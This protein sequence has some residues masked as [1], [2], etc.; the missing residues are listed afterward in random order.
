VAVGV[1]HRGL[2]S[3]VVVGVAGGLRLRVDD[4]G[5]TAGSVVK[6]LRRL[7]GEDIEFETR[8]ATDTG[9]V[10]MDPGQLDQLLMNLTVN[11]RDA[12]PDGG[13]LTISTRRLALTGPQDSPSPELRPGAYALIEVRDTGTGMTQDVQ[14]HI[15]E[16]FFTTKEVGR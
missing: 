2:I 11:A 9:R 7:I 3:R 4:A 13:T 1:G 10:Q 8:L 5:Q 6:M 14:A 12:M 16:P 15:F